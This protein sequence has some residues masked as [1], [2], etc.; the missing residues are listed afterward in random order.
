M[1][2]K[3]CFEL[4]KESINYCLNDF[5]KHEE[6]ARLHDA[7]PALPTRVVD[8]ADPE[9]PRLVAAVGARDRYVALSYVWGGDQLHKTQTTNIA[10]YMRGID[11]ALLPQTIRDAIWTTHALDMRYLWTDT[12]CIIQDDADDRNRELASMTG[13]YTNAHLTIV[14]ASASH[15]SQ[16]FLHTREDLAAQEDAPLPLVL[17]DGTSGTLWASRI[18]YAPQ[19]A[20]SEPI[21]GRGWCFQEAVLSA[22]CIVFATHT[23]IF[24]CRCTTECVG[25]AGNPCWTDVGQVE[26]LHQYKLPAPGGFCGKAYSERMP[27]QWKALLREYS[28]TSVTQPADRL[29]AFAGVA[30]RF[31]EVFPGVRYYAGLWEDRLVEHLHWFVET[32]HPPVLPAPAPRPAAYRAP[33]WSWASVDGGIEF[34]DLEYVQ[35]TFLA[36]VVRCET[37]PKHTELPFGE[38]TTGTLVLRAPVI[39]CK[40]Q[41]N[42]KHFYADVSIFVDDEGSAVGEMSDHE[43]GPDYSPTKVGECLP[44]SADDAQDLPEW[45]SLVLLAKRMGYPYHGYAGFVAKPQGQQFCRVGWFAHNGNSWNWNKGEV[46]ERSQAALENGQIREIVIV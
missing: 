38:V 46:I 40:L 24:Q 27:F 32:K 36:H 11:L 26:V 29:V 43:G 6:C 2:S 19:Y 45:G 30:E 31:S 35:V 34:E 4:V 15:A 41:R 7:V 44:D 39:P 42:Q 1:C 21:S 23:V 37:T 5:K 14:A 13:I 10:A 28:R 8:C 12:L 20:G 18:R 9:H 3:E 22:R 33:T 25:G 16:G 17:P